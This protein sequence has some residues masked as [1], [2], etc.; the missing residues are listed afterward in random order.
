MSATLEDREGVAWG[1]VPEDATELVK[2]V[3]ELRQKE[4]AE[5]SAEDL[6][7]LVGQDVALD[8]VIPAALDVLRDEPVLEA[9]L[10]PGDLLV[11]I[12]NVREDFW[13]M[14]RQLAADVVR[15]LDSLEQT[16][17]DLS[18]DIRK[19]RDRTDSTR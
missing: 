10:Y 11:A 12:L 9:S 15:L 16:P 7:I 6:R 3:Y 19:F 5:L 13:N 8:L 2:R 14:R 1:P 17:A 18:P 4:I